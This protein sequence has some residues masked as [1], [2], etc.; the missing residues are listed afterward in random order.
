[1]SAPVGSHPARVRARR[2]APLSIR[3][4]AAE[5][6]RLEALAG[7]Q[8]VSSFIKEV[9]FGSGGA[10]PRRAARSSGVDRELL[11]RV[12]SALGQSRLSSNLNQI[13]K[14]VNLGCLPV[15]PETESGLRDACHAVRLMRNALLGAL[16]V[17]QRERAADAPD[18]SLVP[19]FGMVAP[20]GV[21]P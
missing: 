14:A 9:V 16:G 7:A 6:A 19:S 10:V 2:A 3:L 11:G 21:Q 1:M 20:R 15:T 18:A 13:A 8:P 17:E 5:R 4:T 12:L